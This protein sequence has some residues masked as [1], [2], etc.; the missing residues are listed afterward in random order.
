MRLPAVRILFP[1]IFFILF[2]FSSLAFGAKASRIELLDGKVYENVTFTVDSEYKI[3]TIKVGDWKRAVDFSDIAQI[4]DED[5]QNVT[6]YHLGDYYKPPEKK[7]EGEWLSNE[8]PRYKTLQKRPFDFGIR[9][10]TNYSFPIGDYYNGVKSGIGYGFDVFIPVTK[11]VAIRGTISKSGMKNDLKS[12]FGDMTILK[13]DLSLNAWRY[14]VSGQYY[15]WPGWKTGAKLLYY[16]F[17]GLGVITHKFSGSATIQDPISGETVIL[18]G[19]GD[20]EDKFMITYGG[21]LI[22]MISKRVGIELGATFDLIFVR[23]TPYYESTNA[24][25]FDLK[26]GLV[27]LF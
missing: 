7:R 21:G 18:Y 15:K 5:G 25:V 26:V 14:A 2:S 20:S 17:V 3:I 24:A 1:F 11:N 9:G 13:D 19:T 16:G 23:G 8:D 22:T 27:G 4:V 10:G 12:M 6:A